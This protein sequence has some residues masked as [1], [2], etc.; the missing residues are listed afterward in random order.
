MYAMLGQTTIYQTVLSITELYLI[1]TCKIRN[2]CP[3]SYAMYSF[4]MG[5]KWNT[6]IRVLFF[7]TPKCGRII[8]QSI[9]VDCPIWK[10]VLAMYFKICINILKRLAVVLH[11]KTSNINIPSQS[12]LLFSLGKGSSGFDQMRLR[13][14]S[15]PQWWCATLL[16]AWPNSLPNRFKKK[17]NLL[18][19]LW[20]A[21]VC[22][23]CKNHP[24]QPLKL[25]FVFKLIL[26]DNLLPMSHKPAECTI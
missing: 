25:L 9:S 3:L 10:I 1:K 24:K 5:K 17:K 23:R 2:S 26:L 4:V 21:T 8:I 20:Q 19:N 6:T 11:S 7:F 14:G 22:V 15:L 12:S 16:P 13:F 18:Q